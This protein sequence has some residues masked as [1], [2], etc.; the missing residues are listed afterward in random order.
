MQQLG[1]RTR[2]S[3][4]VLQYV[5]RLNEKVNNV[6]NVAEWQAYP[7]LAS[8]TFTRGLARSSLNR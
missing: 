8:L 5:I 3:F 7:R 2:W 6:A 4:V 1:G